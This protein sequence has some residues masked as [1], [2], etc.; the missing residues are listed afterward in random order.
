MRHVLHLGA[1]RIEAHAFPSTSISAEYTPSQSRLLPPEEAT[2][3]LRRLRREPGAPASLRRLLAAARPAAIVASLSDTEVEEAL[4]ALVR[5][6]TLRL[7]IAPPPALPT[8]TTE[9]ADTPPPPRP[10]QPRP[11][12]LFWLTIGLVDDAGTPVPRALYR[13]ELADGRTVEGRLNSAGRV[14][15]DDITADGMNHITFPEIDEHLGT[16]SSDED[17]SAT[18][19]AGSTLWTR[20]PETPD[21]PGDPPPPSLS[22]PSTGIASPA[23]PPSACS[24]TTNTPPSPR[25]SP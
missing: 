7:F 12:Q 6:A 1:T 2:S 24:A 8:F 18:P 19:P 10:E 23:G 3:L 14:R 15:W 4:C 13:A 21:S 25:P 5:T 9:D 22:T 16:T 11:R 17:P 20:G